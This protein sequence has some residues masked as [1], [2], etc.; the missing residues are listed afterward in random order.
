M[1]VVSD[2]SPIN[3]LVRLGHT[4][5]LPV[6]FGSVLIPPAVETELTRASTPAQVKD[7]VANRPAWLT[8]RTPASIER[9]AKLDPGEEAAISLAREVKADLVLIDDGDARK[10]A[11]M[12]GLAVIGLLGILERADER[13]LLSLVDAVA[14][15]PDD[16]RIDPA[17][18]EAAL[19]RRRQRE[20]SL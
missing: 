20:G 17:I 14:S 10:A 4:D 15:L 2:S 5:I 16:Y 11:A 13:Q 6:L 1:L 3:F 12:R 19:E 9:I 8:V 7:F 18:V